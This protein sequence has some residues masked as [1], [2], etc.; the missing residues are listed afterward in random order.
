M[1]G[2][3][4]VGIYEKAFPEQLSLAEMLQYAKQAGY[5]FYELNIDRT[6]KRIGRLYD[7]AFPDLLKSAADRTGMRISSI[8]LSALGTYTL[9]NRDLEISARGMEIL[10]KT[11]LLAEDLGT[12]TIQIPA[13][14][15]PKGEAADENT[16]RRFL[17][18]MRE[19]VEFA[20]AHAV[21]LGLENMENA[22]MNSIEKCSTILEAV[23]SPYLQLYPDSGNLTNAWSNDADAILRDMEKVKG[24]CLAFHLKEVIPTR[25]GGLFY[26]D[27]IVDFPLLT[28]KAFDVGAR[29]FV[30][31]YWYTGNP[32]WQDDLKKARCLCDFCLKTNAKEG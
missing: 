16:H 27:G 2:A 7:P 23:S 17:R 12:R 24:H 31:E 6:E 8:G 5:D 28:K 19:A 22:Y 21:V 10:K 1:M 20:S 25:F 11:I 13:C 30:M 29:R 18:N 9:G 3:Y 14:D 4:L 32:N 15:M 26:G